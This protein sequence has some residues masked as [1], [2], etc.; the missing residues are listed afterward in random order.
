MA[1]Q[2]ELPI[3][4][5]MVLI[6]GGICVALALLANTLT[7]R[8]DVKT[9]QTWLPPKSNAAKREFEIYALA[10]TVVWIGVFAMVI[11]W[12]MYEQF[13]ANSY[14]QLCLPLAA[15]FLLQPIFFPLKSEKA[16]P[17]HL[18]YSFKANVWLAIFSFVGNYWYTH[19]FYSV[20][21]AE[22]TFPAHRL[23]D[24]PIALF[25][26][27]HFYFVTYHTFSN[28]ILRRIETRY[29]PGPARTVFFWAAVCA[30]SY[31]TAFMETLTI[32]NFPYY[33]F[34]DRDMAYK[35]GSM[36]YGLYFLVSFPVFYRIDEKIGQKENGTTVVP[37]SIFQTIFE[38]LGTCMLVLI[39]LDAGRL[40]IAEPFH[41]TGTWFYSYDAAIHGT[42][43]GK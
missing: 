4:I 22:Y 7:L 11:L 24:V 40:L 34:V 1:E 43:H 27:T 39:L 28:I 25:F 32:S 37:H 16:L 9:V 12:Q 3:E 18:R 13:T 21:K 38:S 41:M 14:L 20:L 26:A 31:F 8:P 35:V 30:F 6:L 19:Y 2:G 15:P 29:L 36:F 33:R 5:T 42:R 17:L 23:N 10:Y